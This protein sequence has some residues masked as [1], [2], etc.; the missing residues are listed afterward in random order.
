MRKPEILKGSNIASLGIAIYFPFFF[1]YN[2][3]IASEIISPLPIGY[4]SLLVPVILLLYALNWALYR[5]E[6][7][8]Y[9][10]VAL[11][12]L[13]QQLSMMFISVF[14]YYGSTALGEYSTDMLI[15]V[16]SGCLLNLGLF[17]IGRS[18]STP[19]S[20]LWFISL[21]CIFFVSIYNVGV[22][23]VFHIDTHSALSGKVA[24]YQSMGSSI[25]ITGIMLFA[26]SKSYISYLIFFLSLVSLFINGARTEL[27]L[28]FIG[29]LTCLFV[30]SERKTNGII[31]VFLLLFVSISIGVAYY[32]SNPT[33]R[34]FEFIVENTSSS[35]SARYE[36]FIYSVDVIFSDVCKLLIGDYG[37]YYLVNGPGSYPHNLFSA[38]HNFGIM[39]FFSYVLILLLCLNLC[40]NNSNRKNSFY[41]FAVSLLVV[42]SIAFLISKDNSYMIFGLLV[43]VLSNR[44]FKYDGVY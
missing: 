38:W 17:Y 27:F 37:S 40:I 8:R 34:I 1:F 26:F 19:Q 21:L 9:D 16:F 6:F 15:W 14:K 43:G 32:V 3:I 44:K 20:K 23:N 25:M 2:W 10:V 36:M 4:F 24:S 35:G 39:G 12:F 42:V 33:S 29:V 11:L 13:F 31:S 28:Y 5:N 18:L 30:R 41:V 22:S 7:L